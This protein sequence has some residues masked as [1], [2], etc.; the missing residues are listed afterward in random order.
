MTPEDREHGEDVRSGTL[1]G[2]ANRA[3]NEGRLADARDLLLVA[4]DAQEETGRYPRSAWLDRIGA[5]RLHVL[6]WA[7]ENVS[8]SIERDEVIPIRPRGWG[9]GDP[10]S[11]FTVGSGISRGAPIKVRVD[12]RGRVRWVP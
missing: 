6:I 1:R 7:R 12:R 8:P 10:V 3:Y 9:V 11:E 2:D 5:M 4:A